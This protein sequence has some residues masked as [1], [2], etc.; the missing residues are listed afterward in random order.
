MLDLL[1]QVTMPD[2][3]HPL[4]D[5]IGAYVSQISW[6]SSLP[7]MLRPVGYQ[8]VY[9]FTLEP[10]I[11]AQSPP[12]HERIKAQRAENEQVLTERIERAKREK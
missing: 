5:D 8:F 4:P 9:P 6:H 1:D 2:D 11:L 3:V 10:H 7:F 12:V